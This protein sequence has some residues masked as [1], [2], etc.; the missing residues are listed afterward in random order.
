M[1]IVYT[2]IIGPYD[3]LIEQP[4]QYGW[5]YICLTDQPFTS[6]TW[7]IHHIKPSPKIFRS[8]KIQP[9]VYLPPH[10]TSI[11]IDGNLLIDC[12]LDKLVDDNNYY[13]MQ[14]PERV[15]VLLEFNACKRLKK[16][17]S[18]IIDA[19]KWRYYK[20]GFFDSAEAKKLVATGVIVRK[21]NDANIAFGEHWA[22]EVMKGSLRDQLS[23]NFS[24][25]RTGHNYTTF[26]F[27]QG[28]KRF[29]HVKH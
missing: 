8:I 15:E 26:P 1:K 25:W 16:D 13:L 5:R 17:H 3:K 14:H 4:R 9:Y 12:D 24:A 28:F 29:N 2:A 10:E 18:A 22:N 20:E 27:L 7:E 19:Q 21:H 23:F 11:W 6:N